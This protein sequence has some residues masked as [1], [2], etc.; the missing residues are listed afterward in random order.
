[1]A[2]LD[3]LSTDIPVIKPSDTGS[4]ILDLMQ[5]E[6]QT[7][8]PLLNGDQYVALIKE[9]D[10][11]EW[12]QQENAISTSEFL[13]FRP[14]VLDTAHPY[15]AA[16]LLSELSIPFVPIL[17]EGN[18]YLGVVTAE[19]LLH[20]FCKNSGLNHAGGIIVLSVKPND[21]SLSEISRICE[22]NDAIILNVQVM[23]EHAGELMDVIIKT[24]TKDLQGLRA[25]FERYEYTIKEIYGGIVL[26]ND[27]EDRYKLL[28]NYINM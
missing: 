13:H 19:D 6:A 24:N 12:P 3:Y 9:T 27:V 1:M 4:G 8:L 26:Q 16:V 2:I 15:D 10:I 28:M 20:F 7:A 11:L 5:A 25:S 18:K 22:S 17:D 21:Y 23:I 14:M